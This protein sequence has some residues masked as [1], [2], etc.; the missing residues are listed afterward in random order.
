MKITLLSLGVTI[1][2]IRFAC[3]GSL[4][5]ANHVLEQVSPDRNMPVRFQV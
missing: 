3:H 1:D 5:A 2:K 4:K